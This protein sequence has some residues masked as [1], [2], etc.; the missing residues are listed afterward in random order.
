MEYGEAKAVGDIGEQRV[1]ERLRVYCSEN[2][3]SGFLSNV[4]VRSGRMTAQLDHVLIDPHGIL[5]VEVKVRNGRIR[6]TADEKKWTAVYGG[7]TKTF[8]NP[9]EQLRGQRNTLSK[10]LHGISD[11]IDLDLIQ[12]V[13]VFVDADISALELD[14]HSRKHVTTLDRLAAALR[15]RT[16]Q[17]AAG[18]THVEVCRRYEQ[19]RLLDQSADP[20]VQAAHAD[21]R[22]GASASA[23]ARAAAPSQPPRTAPTTTPG[24]NASRLA[25]GSGSRSFGSGTRSPAFDSPGGWRSAPRSRAAQKFREFVATLAVLALF[26]ACVATGAFQGALTAI[27]L[28]ALRLN[29]PAA[30]APSITPSS[31]PTL[32]QAK[33]QLFQV[34]PQLRGAVTDLET[35][36]TTASG[37][38]VTYVW[39][40][41]SKA[42]ASRVVIKTCGLALGP[43]GVLRAV[44]P[45]Q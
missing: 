16:T 31:A 10:A 44:L 7:M 17:E 9:L 27:L 12:G 22:G 25:S 15:E 28:P 13:V 45:G 33:D 34:A 1:A 23:A 6:G 18:L 43:G 8:Q 2:P 37:D 30:T 29:A 24:D 38:S 14:S 42:S 5:I 39:H 11:P 40:Y 4:L 36:T 26:W 20:A 32:A 35:P 21:Y 3:P 19:L 41:A